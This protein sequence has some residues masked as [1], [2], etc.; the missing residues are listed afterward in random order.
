MNLYGEI[1]FYNVFKLYTAKISIPDVEYLKNK[2]FRTKLDFNSKN[3]TFT[4]YI[5]A[6]REL[7][8]NN[9]ISLVSSS[10]PYG[11]IISFYYIEYSSLALFKQDIK[12]NISQFQ[13]IISPPKFYIK[14]PVLNIISGTLESKNK[15]TSIEVYQ[16]IDKLIEQEIL[17]D[18]QGKFYILEVDNKKINKFS[19]I[20]IFNFENYNLTTN[21]VS[22]TVVYSKYMNSISVSKE[23]K[24]ILL[25]DVLNTLELKDYFYSNII[26]QQI[27]GNF[28]LYTD[29]DK[30]YG[31]DLDISNLILNGNLKIS[32]SH[33]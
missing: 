22:G 32:I 8:T 7:I 4:L 13:N 2:K 9:I 21:T 26:E 14:Y 10:F 3:S 6:P 20:N 27:S 18:R 16:R 24:Y 11:D 31:I 5:L 17:P 33:T 29:K 30:I 1:D 23:S 28:T 19:V 15:T 12:I 25:H